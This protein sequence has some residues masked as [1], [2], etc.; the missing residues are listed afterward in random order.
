[1][2]DAQI[3]GFYASQ[4]ALLKGVVLVRIPESAHVI[5]WDQPQR[6]QNEVTEFLR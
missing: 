3:D 5:M 2:T 1:V 6:F 4:Y